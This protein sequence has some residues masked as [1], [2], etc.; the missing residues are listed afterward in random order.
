MAYF[1]VFE[2]LFEWSCYI[3]AILFAFDFSDCHKSTGIRHDWQWQI[4]A[5][6]ITAAWLI[7]LSNIRKFP[8][9]GI[10]IVMFTNVLQTFLKLSVIIAMFIVA[11]SL[12]F[13]CLL[14]NQVNMK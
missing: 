9:I 13:H 4:G 1:V 5:Y 11:F 12:G 3:S 6:A 14:A 2:N 8:F 10:Y 7:L